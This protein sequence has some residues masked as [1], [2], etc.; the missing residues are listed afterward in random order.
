M[1]LGC[2]WILSDTGRLT[3]LSILDVW[4]GSEYASVKWP[5]RRFTEVICWLSEK[6]A[7]ILQSLKHQLTTKYGVFILIAF[8]LSS[9]IIWIFTE[10]EMKE[11]LCI[12]LFQG[13]NT[14]LFHKNSV[15]L[16][17]FCSFKGGMKSFITKS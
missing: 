14:L 9:R 15:N 2:G 4:E 1:T 5:L 17:E 16:I 10:T 8:S 6:L 12:E 13:I 3:L 11:L 7:L